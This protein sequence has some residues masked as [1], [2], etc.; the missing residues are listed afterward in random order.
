MADGSFCDTSDKPM[1]SVT[2]NVCRS[3]AFPLPLF[4]L[5]RAA[6]EVALGCIKPYTPRANH[7]ILP[8]FRLPG[9]TPHLS[10][11]ALLFL[12]R[13]LSPL[14]PSAASPPPFLCPTS[15]TSS[16]PLCHL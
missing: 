14:T 4:A 8:H 1:G 13:L 2:L 9:V 16:T 6:L 12:S 5:P 15:E 11:F 3:P 10:S 7:P